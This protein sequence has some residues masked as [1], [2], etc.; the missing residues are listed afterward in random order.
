[1]AMILAMTGLFIKRLATGVV[2][3]VIMSTS[4]TASAQS[5]RKLDEMVFYEG[6]LFKLKLVRYYENLPPHYTGEVFRVQ[7]ASA[8]TAN[9]PGHKMQ[10]QG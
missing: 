7:C 8:K 9:S 3:S 6:P 10:D 2:V 5:T 1:M 4:L